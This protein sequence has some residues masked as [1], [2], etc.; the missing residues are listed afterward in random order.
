MGK[1][2]RF[3]EKNFIDLDNS[4]GTITASQA[5]VMAAYARNRSLR[6]AWMTTDSVDADNTTLEFDLGAPYLID[7]IL[8]VD[9]NLKSYKL[10][11]YD[12]GTGLWTQFY[13]TTCD[14][15]ETS[16]I[17][18]VEFYG[19]R[20][21]ITI[22]GTQ[23]ADSDK[24][25]GRL[26]VTKQIGQFKFWPKISKPIHDEGR[27]ARKTLSGK[28]A[29]LKTVGAFSFTLQMASWNSPADIALIEILY[30]QLQ[31]IEVWICGGNEE[32][33]SYAAEGYRRK[34]IYLM[35]LASDWS[36]EFPDAIYCNGLKIDLSFVEV[37]G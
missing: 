26:I 37:V 30:A 16:E 24:R 15:Q 34:D 20:I 11:L 5:D 21:R 17:D 7:T 10:E 32:Q 22:Y 2:I 28:V 19:Q 27:S 23:M 33:F 36:P 13:I 12:S 3:F 29:M 25:V 9:H 18:L 14:D 4:D 8:L 1:Q 6:Y 35:G 31:G